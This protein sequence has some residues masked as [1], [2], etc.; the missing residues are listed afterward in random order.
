MPKRK[1]KGYRPPTNYVTQLRPEAPVAME[2]QIAKA[3]I[4]WELAIRRAKDTTDFP[5]GQKLGARRRAVKT[6]AKNLRKLIATMI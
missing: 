4:K 2:L 1:P 5:S 6:T 3:A